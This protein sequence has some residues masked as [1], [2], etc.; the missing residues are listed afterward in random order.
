LINTDFRGYIDKFFSVE[1]FQFENEE[2]IISAL[3]SIISRFKVPKNQTLK[4][5]LGTKGGLRIYLLDIFIKSLRLSGRGKLNL[6]EILKGI[7]YSFNTVQLIDDIAYRNN[8]VKIL[9]ILNQLIAILVS[10]FGGRVNNLTTIL[11]KIILSIKNKESDVGSAIEIEMAANILLLKIDPG[12]I[13]NKTT[14]IPR[15]WDGYII[16][17]ANRE[18]TKIRDSQGEIVSTEFIFYKLLI[19]YIEG[20]YFEDDLENWDWELSKEL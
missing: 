16:T 4:R 11:Q 2:I 1:A 7:S 9:R 20:G 6:R 10:V 3:E 19:K 14:E 15:N 12:I 13:P 5:E 18:I 17:T 8:E